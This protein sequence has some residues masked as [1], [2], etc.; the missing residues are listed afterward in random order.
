[1]KIRPLQ[2]WAVIRPNLPLEKTAAG[3]VIPDVAKEKPQEG[4]VLA[5]GEGRFVEKKDKK[6]NVIEKKFVKTS[7]KPGDRV[8]F[9]RYSAVK[10]PESASGGEEMVM[11]REEDVLGYLEP[12]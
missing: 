1:M 5:I 8:L 2:D 10:V 11:V 6:G 9:E 7:L 12:I 3:I 4:K